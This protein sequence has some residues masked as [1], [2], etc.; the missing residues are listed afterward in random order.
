[1]KVQISEMVLDG[2]RRNLQIKESCSTR[3]SFPS[4]SAVLIYSPKVGLSCRLRK[5]LQIGIW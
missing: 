2:T 1:M 3:P 5:L 4:C